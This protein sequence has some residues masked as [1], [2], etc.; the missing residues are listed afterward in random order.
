[1]IVVRIELFVELQ[2][3][4]VEIIPNEANIPVLHSPTSLTL[5]QVYN[6]KYVI[7]VKNIITYLQFANSSIFLYKKEG[8]LKKYI[9]IFICVVY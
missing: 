6:C 4:K 1:M 5:Y 9:F 7:N 3:Y 2:I 8:V